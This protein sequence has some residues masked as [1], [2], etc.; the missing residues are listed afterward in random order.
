MTE[1]KRTTEL[2]LEKLG[3]ENKNYI[4]ELETRIEILEQE[5]KQLK[6]VINQNKFEKQKETLSGEANLE[7]V[8]AQEQKFIDQWMN[9]EGV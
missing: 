1:R 4:S 5:N 9:G 3:R 7:S 2:R 6:E 8:K